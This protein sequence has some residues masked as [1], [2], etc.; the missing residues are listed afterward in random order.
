MTVKLAGLKF[1][2]IGEIGTTGTNIIFKDEVSI[3]EAVAQAGDIPVTGDRKNV[4]IMRQ[5]PD[6]VR[7]HKLD[8]TDINVVN[9]PFYFVQPNDVIIVDP[10][11]QKS[12]G[13]GTTGLDTFRTTL[14]VIT[15]LTSIILL[16]IS[17]SN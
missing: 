7:V 11:P 3:I 4:R 1:T 15:G 10:L 12:I 9:S 16:A 6:G 2:T 5:Y 13:T 8:L 17:L 14:T